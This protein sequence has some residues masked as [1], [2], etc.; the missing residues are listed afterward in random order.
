MASQVEF[1]FWFIYVDVYV[2]S[3][4]IYVDIYG[5]YVDICRSWNNSPINFSVDIYLFSS[6]D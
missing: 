5:F 3:P 2:F 4:D 1:N 6:V